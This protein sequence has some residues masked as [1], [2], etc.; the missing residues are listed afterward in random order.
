MYPYV[1]LMKV[2]LTSRFKSRISFDSVSELKMRVWPG[3]IDFYPEMNN[4]RHLTLMDLGRMDLA[5]RSGLIK[6]AH[7]NGWGFVVAG[8]SVR[9]RRKLAPFRLFALR[10]QLV[11]MHDRWFYFHQTTERNGRV[12]SS[13]LVRA[14]IKS[15][16]GLVPVQEV[17]AAIGEEYRTMEMPD[18]VHDWIE[19]E[20]RRPIL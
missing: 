2:L 6:A 11:G 16:D 20:E 14:A 4:G 3:D 15:K 17:L 5:A 7:Q 19:A 8:A 12:C 10:T 1:R 13:A 9:Y 18:W